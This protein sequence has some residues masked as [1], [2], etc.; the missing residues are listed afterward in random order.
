M[1]YNN[2]L[3]HTLIS[4]FPTMSTISNL[5]LPLNEA[6]MEQLDRFLL[7]RIDDDAVTEEMDA[8]IFD[9]STLDGFFTAIVS[10]PDIIPPS[11]WLPS[12]WGD[13]EPEWKSEEAF[14]EVIALLMRHMN[15]IVQV[16]MEYPE[17]F[18]PI[19]FERKVKDKTYTIVDEWCEG[20]YRG[21]E[22]LSMQWQTGGDEIAAL[23][24]P[25]FAF[26]EA[27]EWKAHDLPEDEL[28]QLQQVIAPN[29]REIHAYW[30]E[31]RFDQPPLDLPIRRS[32][33]KVGRNDPCPCGSGKKYKKCCLH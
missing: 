3:T 30:L 15:G 2:H 20:Y 26:T 32:E 24:A 28:E 18:E 17:D 6:E 13:F 19:F 16:L 14:S 25:I 12:V 1:F 4:P 22:L 8:G 23:L 29:A 21:A 5:D 7:N 10:G 31:R 27:L 9:I 11:V 33:P